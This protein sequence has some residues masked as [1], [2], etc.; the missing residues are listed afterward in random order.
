MKKALVIFSIITLL[1]IFCF[2]IIFFNLP[3]TGNVIN[4]NSNS[5]NSIKKQKVEITMENF[6]TYLPKTEL[7]KD[8]PSQTNLE[9][10][11]PEKS[12]T[13]QKGIFKEGMPTNPDVTIMIPSKYLPEITAN[14][15]SALTKITTNR[16]LDYQLHI[17]K[18][19]AAFKYRSL[20]KYKDCL[21]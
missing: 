9:L 5:I 18:I 1:V 6:M 3:Q 16:D 21:K 12:Y 8:L 13:I 15:C 17:S 4:T 7:I 20:Y 11:T 2:V 10:K 19:S 14:P